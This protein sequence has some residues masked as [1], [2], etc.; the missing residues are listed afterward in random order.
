M[1]IQKKNPKQTQQNQMKNK[2]LKN[3]LISLIIFLIFLAGIHLMVVE[4]VLSDIYKQFKI[5][6]IYLFLGI[7]SVLGISAIFLIHKNDDTLIGKGYLVFVVFKILGSFVF[8]YPWLADQ[9]DS[10]RPFVYQ[11]FAIF[12]P[13]LLFE[14]LVI[15]KVINAIEE[16]KTI[17]DENQSEK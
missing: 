7:L 12:F 10:T 6:Y 16:E 9:D 2:Q 4:F 11:F 13:T 8:L 1:K 3:S 17:I 15:L 5:V 14:T